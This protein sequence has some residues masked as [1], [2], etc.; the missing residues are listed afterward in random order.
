[1]KTV[2]KLRAEVAEGFGTDIFIQKVTEKIVVAIKNEREL[3]QF[4]LDDGRPRFK[5]QGPLR[6]KNIERLH[7]FLQES[8]RSQWNG[9]WKPKYNS[10]GEIVYPTMPDSSQFKTKEDWLKYLKVEIIDLNSEIKVKRERI[11]HPF[12]YQGYVYDGPVKIKIMENDTEESVKE[13]LRLAKI[14]YKNYVKTK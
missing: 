5:D 1:M 11:P 6:I 10:R 8:C 2:L 13:R 7:K 14:K 4:F 12:E 9:N 3:L